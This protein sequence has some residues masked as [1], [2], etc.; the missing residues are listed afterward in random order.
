MSYLKFKKYICKV[1]YKIVNLLQILET[2]Q[3]G[4]HCVARDFLDDDVSKH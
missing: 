3:I 2:K 4:C 1:N